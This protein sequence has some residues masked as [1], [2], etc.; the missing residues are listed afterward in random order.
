MQMTLP[1]TKGKLINIKHTMS[2]SE[3]KTTD[4]SFSELKDKSK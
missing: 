2:K 4:K 3:L 1:G